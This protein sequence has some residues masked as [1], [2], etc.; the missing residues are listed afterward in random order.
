MISRKNI[1]LVFRVAIWMRW[2]RFRKT[3]M[4]RNVLIINLAIDKNQMS[5]LLIER[6]NFGLCRNCGEMAASD[7]DDMNE[8]ASPCMQGSHSQV[9]HKFVNI[10]LPNLQIVCLK[11]GH[12]HA[13]NSF[14]LQIIY[15]WAR[16]A[17]ILE[18]PEGVG[19]KVGKTSPIQYLVLQV[20]YAHIHKFSGKLLIHFCG[21]MTAAQA[22]KPKLFQPNFLSS[23]WLPDGST[24]DS[25]IFLHYT[26]QT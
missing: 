1:I 11:Y 21:L 12:T 18:L 26:K 25:G 19:F 10:E 4:V 20:H 9:S 17:P 13:N 3:R 22:N 5:N 24:D 6:Q 14:K 16:D 8:A 15:A 2:T 7:A 23:I